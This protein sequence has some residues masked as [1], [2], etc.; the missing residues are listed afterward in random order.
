MEMM[1]N[2]PL[3]F[4]QWWGQSVLTRTSAITE[5]SETEKQQVSCSCWSPGWWWEPG[6]SSICY[7]VFPGRGGTTFPWPLA[8]EQGILVHSHYMSRARNSSWLVFSLHRRELWMQEAVSLASDLALL[9][10][11]H[12]AVTFGSVTHIFHSCFVLEGPGY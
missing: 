3:P 4:S 5:Y 8:A 9:F 2:S 1:S 6:R 10:S 11:L 12:Q 7:G